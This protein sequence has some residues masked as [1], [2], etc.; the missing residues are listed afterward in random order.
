[1]S[2]NNRA[3]TLVELIMVI[4]IISIIALSTSAIIM[5]FMRNT[6]FLPRQMNVQQIADAAMD[7]MIEGLRFSSRVTEA[8]NNNI[9]FINAGGD[10]IRFR[11]NNNVITR[12]INV[13]G[14]GTE[15]PIPYYATG[16][17]TISGEGNKLFRFYDE[18]DTPMATPTLENINRV[19]IKM[20]VKSGTGEFNDW[21]GKIALGSSV[22]ICRVN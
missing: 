17:I 1:M 22:K 10:D 16:N 18:T 2:N 11:I 5:F 4:V 21:E 6:I 8:G 13:A 9:R 15:E 12:T 14:G 7:I 19:E 3:F 20:I